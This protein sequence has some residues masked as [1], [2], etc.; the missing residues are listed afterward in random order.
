MRLAILFI[1]PPEKDFDWDPKAVAG[2]NRFIKRAWNI[3]CS[4]PRTPRQARST[5]RP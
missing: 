4:S 1:A 2:A 5:T 3:V